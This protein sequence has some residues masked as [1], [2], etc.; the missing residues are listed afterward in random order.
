[1][2]LSQTLKFKIDNKSFFF[3]VNGNDWELAR[4]GIGEGKILNC[5]IFF[6]VRRQKKKLCLARGCRLSKRS[7]ELKSKWLPPKT[8]NKRVCDVLDANK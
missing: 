1:M 6:L 4:G 5:N 7:G 8:W 2:K 3:S